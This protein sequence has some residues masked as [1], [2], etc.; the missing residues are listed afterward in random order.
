MQFS[1]VI[2]NSNLSGKEYKTP[3]TGNVNSYQCLFEINSDIKNLE[4]FCVF[5]V[6][7]NCYVQ[8]IVDNACYI[9]KEVLLSENTIKIGC[10]AT[11]MAE[12][13]Y[14]RI[15]TNWLY[16]KSLE[17]AYTEG[18]LP[19]IPEPD[20]WETLVAK[21]V[22]VIGENGNW[23]TYSMTEGEYVDTGMPASG[24]GEYPSNGYT[25]E[26][27]DKK[28][29]NKVDKKEGYGLSQIYAHNIARFTI[30]GENYQTTDVHCH[31]QDGTDEILTVYE[32]AV[33]NQMIGD[34]DTALENIIA[35]YG[36]G[37]D[38]I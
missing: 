4:W 7:D 8:H 9:P 12:N 3:F 16:F 19:E 32:K 11:N 20:V 21:S 13:D 31:K 33:I 18:T 27:I 15:S 1:F 14:K 24:G 2:N 23:Y 35:K 5:S 17:G 22:P 25:N 36:L 28:L 10:Y 26:E 37:G 6:D 30:D 38:V 29:I 34:I